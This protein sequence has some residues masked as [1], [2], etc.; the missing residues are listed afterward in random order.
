MKY[1][2][3]FNELTLSYENGVSNSGKENKV[4]PLSSKEELIS[5]SN[6]ASCKSTDKID[7]LSLFCFQDSKGRRTKDAWTSSNVLALDIDT[8]VITSL[9]LSKADILFEKI[10]NLVFIQE[11][12]SGKLHMLLAIPECYSENDYK[13]IGLCYYQLVI[14][15]INQY[16]YPTNLIELNPKDHPE[17]KLDTLST[18]EKEEAIKNNDY[19][20]LNNHSIDIHSINNLVQAFHM[21]F[22]EIHFNSN[23]EIDTDL[24]S[25]YILKVVDIKNSVFY[26]FNN[27]KLNLKDV[28]RRIIVNQVELDNILV[29][30]NRVLINPSKGENLQFNEVSGNINNINQSNTNIGVKK[31]PFEGFSLNE[32]PYVENRINL[33]FT[34]TASFRN[35][36][37]DKLI[38]FYK[39]TNGGR[40]HLRY[41]TRNGYEEG[42]YSHK[43]KLPIMR[44]KATGAIMKIHQGNSRRERIRQITKIAFLYELAESKT[45]EGNKFYKNNI[46]ATIK[47]FI[48]NC[49]ERIG[50][51][52]NITDELVIELIREVK[53]NFDNINVFGKVN[54]YYMK[55]EEDLDCWSKVAKYGRKINSKRCEV[56]ENNAI[57]FITNNNLLGK[58]N[59]TIANILNESN[60][61]SKG[62]KKWNEDTVK[63]MLLK[64]NLNGSTDD[65]TIRLEELYSEG[66]KY[67]EI[68]SIL[69]LEGYKTKQDKE[70]NAKA[71][72]NYVRRKLK[73]KSDDT[74]EFLIIE[75]VRDEINAGYECKEIAEVLTVAFGKTFSEKDVK[76]IVSRI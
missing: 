76:Q 60:I 36:V 47:W 71:I 28:D 42:M 70:F 34:H 11:S 48:D 3:S 57:S 18:F 22:N 33:D 14:D 8:K 67:G 45:R 29:E 59:K 24:L 10:T 52:R 15:V 65:Y 27:Y 51:T 37:F 17:L 13:F 41:M 35:N 49:I 40:I 54:S 73:N 55:P 53:N 19:K 62:K 74:E 38:T 72:E 32:I 61:A 6:P 7:M 50:S 43:F 12:Y 1:Q 56:I 23:I 21:S 20:K 2:V 63:K 26:Q 31:V 75:K 64:N 9:V 44:D 16:V 68:A 25:E 39:Q 66:K 4:L 5:L 46:I 69:N 58:S 30:N